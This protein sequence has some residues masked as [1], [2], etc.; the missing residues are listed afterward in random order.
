MASQGNGAAVPAH[1]FREYDIRGIVDQD[2]NEDV[3]YNLGRA[4]GT[5]LYS[6][7][8]IAPVRPPRFHVVCGYDARLTGPGPQVVGQ[9]A[10]RAEGD[11]QPAGCARGPE[12]SGVG[13]LGQGELSPGQ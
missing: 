4:Y 11:G 5:F 7:I 12:R 9:P 10:Q 8:G 13:H 2:L 3:Y 1:I 6:Q